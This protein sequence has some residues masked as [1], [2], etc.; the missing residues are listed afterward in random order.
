MKASPC[1][2][3]RGVCMQ[4]PVQ[5]LLAFPVRLEALAH[6][7]A[8][9]DAAFGVGCL[10]SPKAPTRI[11]AEAAKGVQYDLSAEVAHTV[12]RSS[13]SSQSERRGKRSLPSKSKL[14]MQA[15]PTR[16]VRAVCSVKAHR[17]SK[18]SVSSPGRGILLPCTARCRSQDCAL[19]LPSRGQPTAAHVC[20]LRH[21]L[22]RRCLRLMS[23]V[24]P[25]V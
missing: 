4:E 14:S 20:L 8:L 21:H 5:M 2:S 12:A 9:H 13:N 10:R 24:R 3:K 7:E 25:H 17:C 11:A 23:N 15:A 18:G 6:A 22:W 1:T 19:T 16:R